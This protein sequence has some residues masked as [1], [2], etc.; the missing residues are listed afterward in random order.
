MAS[1]GAT[2]GNYL[3]LRLIKSCQNATLIQCEKIEKN[4]L[5]IESVYYTGSLFNLFFLY[6]FHILQGGPIKTGPF[7]KVYDSCI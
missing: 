2:M 6:F 3:Q 5:N 4:E 1:D 7:L